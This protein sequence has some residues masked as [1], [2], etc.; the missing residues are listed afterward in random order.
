VVGAGWGE[1]ACL[2]LA[3]AGFALQAV[4]I[5]GSQLHAL[6]QLPEPARPPAAARPRKK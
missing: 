5:F 4:V 1:A 2:W 6:R 3:L